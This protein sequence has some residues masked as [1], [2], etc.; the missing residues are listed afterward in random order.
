V[1]LVDLLGDALDDLV[2]ALDDALIRRPIPLSG[3]TVVVVHAVASLA[4]ARARCSMML[5]S[6][7]A[8]AR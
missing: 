3:T 6:T 7:T 8:S 5:L 1:S 4:L 2:V